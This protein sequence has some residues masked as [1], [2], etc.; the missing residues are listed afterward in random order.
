V[1]PRAA[2]KENAGGSAV[3]GAE[4]PPPAE[5]EAERHELHARLGSILELVE[6]N[7]A[8]LDSYLPFWR[9]IDEAHPNR[10]GRLEDKVAS[11]ASLLLLLVRRLPPE[12][13]AGLDAVVDR[14]AAR[15]QPLVRNDRFR[16]EILENPE[17]A[18]SFGVGHL[19]LANAGYVDPAWDEIVIPPIRDGFAE[20]RDLPPHRILERL[21]IRE[22]AGMPFDEAR[23]RDAARLSIVAGRA[24]PILM[25]QGDAYAYTHGLMYASDFGRRTVD[26]FFDEAEVGAVVGACIAWTLVEPDFDLVAEFLL[27]ETFLGRGWSDQAT[28]AWG[29]LRAV[30][31]RLGFVPG[32]TFDEEAFSV[33]AGDD[34][35]AYAFKEMY[36]AN[37]VVGALCTSLLADGAEAVSRSSPRRSDSSRS[38]GREAELLPEAL[39]WCRELRGLRDDQTAP[40]EVAIHEDVRAEAAC[41]LLEAAAIH[42]VRAGHVG[43]A[44]DAVDRLRRFGF[45]G[46]SAAAAS[47]HLARLELLRPDELRRRSH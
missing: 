42:A 35:R 40:W 34:R 41:T 3:R 46:G 29:T 32:P 2:G 10:V 16:A 5:V 27:C 9:R 38:D 21:W 25:T 43:I 4:L 20:T 7:L 47:S 30:W 17:R 23:A 28:F 6:R 31:D 33:L 39:V 19:Y 13:R 12:L 8:R 14:V 15:L 45:A 22:L 24:H 18:A 37:V 44:R 36:H 11:E 1:G 26:P